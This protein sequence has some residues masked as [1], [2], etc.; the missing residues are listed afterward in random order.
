MGR[1][2]KRRTLPPMDLTNLDEWTPVEFN[3]EEKLTLLIAV[4]QIVEVVRDSKKC[5]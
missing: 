1:M 3:N 4:C 5:L 2:A